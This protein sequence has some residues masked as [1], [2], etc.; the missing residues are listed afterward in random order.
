MENLEVDETTKKKEKQ[1]RKSRNNLNIISIIT[2]AIVRDENESTDIEETA[3]KV[4]N[5]QD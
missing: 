5:H 2:T 4:N 3:G 1:K